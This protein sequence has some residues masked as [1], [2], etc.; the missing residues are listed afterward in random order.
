MTAQLD[1][2]EARRERKREEARSSQR[3]NWAA[4][5]EFAAALRAS[6]QAQI[7]LL[8]GLEEGRDIK[9]LL[10][11]AVKAVVLIP[12]NDEALTRVRARIKDALKKYV[13][14]RAEESST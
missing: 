3:I 8:T 14:D 11:L 5:E 2:R 9:E 10:M 6:E 12:D 4:V 1:P 13:T 7:D